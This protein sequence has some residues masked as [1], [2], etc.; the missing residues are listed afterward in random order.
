MRQARPAVT[1]KNPG[2]TEGANIEVEEDDADAEWLRLDVN[3]G[4]EGQAPLDPASVS[5]R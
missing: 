2:V 5:G 4:T 1:L 3:L